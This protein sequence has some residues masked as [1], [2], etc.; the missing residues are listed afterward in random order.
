MPRGAARLRIG[1]APDLGSARLCQR[2]VC[3]VRTR[4]SVAGPFAQE[5]W[6]SLVRDQPTLGRPDDVLVEDESSRAIPAKCRFIGLALE[7]VVLVPA[8]TG[9]PDD[10]LASVPQRVRQLLKA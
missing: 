8:Y 5:I 4:I 6:T 9:E 7:R 2:G 3:A 1:A 10:V